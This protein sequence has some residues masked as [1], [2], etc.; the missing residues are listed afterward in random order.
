MHGVDI[1]TCKIQALL[2]VHT[3]DFFLF[4]ICMFPFS[5]PRPELSPSAHCFDDPLF[6]RFAYGSSILDRVRSAFSVCI[7]LLL[8]CWLMLELDEINADDD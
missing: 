8:L 5:A 4:Q 1:V 3:E 6:L 7:F 2:S